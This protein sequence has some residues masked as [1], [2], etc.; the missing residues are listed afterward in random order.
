MATVFMK[1]LER[2]PSDYDQGIGFLTLGKLKLLKKTITDQ[3]IRA[4][5]CV[6]EIGCGTGELALFMAQKGAVVEALDVSSDMLE[7]AQKRIWSHKLENRVNFHLLDGTQA[8]E[9]FEPGSFDVIVATLVFSELSSEK[10]KQTLDVCSRL[11]KPQ[12]R[13]LIADEII[14]ENRLARFQYRLIHYPLSVFTWLLTRTTTNPLCGFPEN[15]RQAG[16]QTRI[17]KA[18]LSGSLVL[19]EAFVEE[20]STSTLAEIP[21]ELSGQLSSR[22]TFRTMLLD[23]WSLFFRMIPPYPKVRPGV[24]SVGIP[25]KDSPV[26]VTGNF[27][28]TVQ[29]LVRA[30][31][32]QLDAW[33]LVVDS[34]GINVWCAAGGRFL[35]AEKVISAIQ[36]S[37]LEYFVNHHALILPQLC[38]NGVDGWKI[39]KETGW[40][41]HW[42]PVRAV[43]IPA[44]FR[45]ARKKSDEMRWVD[46]PLRD[47][48]EMVSVTLGF[49]GLLI[50]I[51]VWIFW[52]NF[53]GPLAISLIGLSFFY[54]VF[55]PW[56]PGKDGL[57]KSIPLAF[58]TLVGLFTYS[59]FW[60]SLTNIQIFNWSIGLIG[61]SVF[62]A[63]EMQGM[64]PRMRG[65][66]ANWGWELLIAVILLLVYWLTPLAL[67]WR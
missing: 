67:G 40:G 65:E 5:D 7:E 61:L 62:T 35:T 24:Y 38:A 45:H 4:G 30:I 29:R 11:L 25:R 43:E 22:H 32:G 6:L 9:S 47:R 54:A 12:G 31:D 51:P 44:Y 49:Y 57:Y 41:V 21:V 15:I 34:A 66:Q 46:F 56:L 2:K 26:L 3:F 64:S 20:E 63:A 16:F 10:Q 42:G 53:F 33:I 8:G 55:Q 23:L 1:W 14:P 28:L 60:G 27:A 58:I 48:L 59:W 39:R 37:Q 17:V 36:S 19:Y 50:L 13:L 18:H 52:R